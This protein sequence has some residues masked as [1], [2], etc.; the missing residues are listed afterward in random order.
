LTIIVAGQKESRQENEGNDMEQ[1][2]GGKL[3][4]L[5]WKAFLRLLPIQIIEIIVF[6]INTFVDSLI[7][8]RCLGTDAMA[9]SVSLVPS[10]W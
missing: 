2:S 10:R 5:V 4:P 6:A 8:S 9:A 7:T 3:S 1:L